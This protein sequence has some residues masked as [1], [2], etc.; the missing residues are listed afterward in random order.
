VGE[1]KLRRLAEETPPPAW[2]LRNGNRLQIKRKL[3]KKL[4][5]SLEAI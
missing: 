2:V 4:I 5:D 1:N 3:F